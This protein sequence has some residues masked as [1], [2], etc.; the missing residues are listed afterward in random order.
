MR[1]PDLGVATD[2][3]EFL[4]L[5]G[6]LPHVRCGYKGNE[7]VMENNPIIASLARPN[8]SRLRPL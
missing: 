1:A 5:H 7:R 8:L 6:L 2:E 3:C 4:G